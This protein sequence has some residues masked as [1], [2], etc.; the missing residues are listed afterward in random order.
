MVITKDLGAV[1]AYAYA[2]EQGYQG[3]EEEF[4]EL[5]ARQATVA[6]EAAASADAAAESASEA[7]ASAE[8]AEQSAQSIS[9]DVELAEQAATTATGKA[10][11]AATSATT[12]NGA[13]QTATGKAAQAEQS[14][15]AAAN[16]AS[17][18]A[19]SATNAAASATAAQTAKTAAE[20]AQGR[21]EQ[22]TQSVSASAAQIAKNTD[23]FASEFSAST[24]YAI[25]DYCIYQG[26]L[27]RFTSAHTGAWSASD[28]EATNVGEEVGELRSALSEV[29]T[30]LGKVESANKF[31]PATALEGYSIGTSG[32]PISSS[33]NFTSDFI[34]C[35]GGDT[36]YYT[37]ARI[38][39]SVHAFYGITAANVS[40]FAQYDENKQFIS[41]TRQQWVNSVVLNADC[42]YVRFSNPLTHLQD[43]IRI[44]SVTFNEYP[45]DWDEVAEYHEPYI[46]LTADRFNE[47]LEEFEDYKDE[48]AT[49]VRPENELDLSRILTNTVVSSSG[50]TYN[51]TCFT[52]DY[53]IPAVYGDVVTY[54][55]IDTNGTYYHT[56]VKMVNVGMYDAD[57]NLLGTSG[58]YAQDFKINKSNC[59]YIR[60]SCPNGALSVRLACVSINAVPVM[61]SMTEY[62]TP[63]YS[64]TK[65]SQDTIRSRKVLWLGTSIPTYG[66]PQILARLCGANMHNEAIGSSC[67]AEGIEPNVTAANVCGIRSIYGLYG[68]TQTIAE[69]QTMIDNWS[70]IASEIGSTDTLTD[71]IRATALASSYETIVDPYLTGENA[72]DLIVLNHAYNDAT[73]Y[74]VAPEGDKLNPHYLEGAYNWLIKRILEANPNIGIVIFG[75]YSD[76]PTSKE[77]ALQNVA[78]RWNIPYYLLKNDLGWSNTQ[79]IT[80]TKRI[81]GS[82]EWETI[83]A[84]DMTVQAM[85]LGDGVH[86]LGVASKR[87]A[88]VSQNVFAD[89]LK[90]Y[91]DA[92]T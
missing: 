78:D 51:D 66:Y 86:P 26:T 15:T 40:H 49:L 36:F 89:W 4:A 33:S 67:I 70:T 68:L 87:I 14:A 72:V 54:T 91:C 69:K 39:D 31:N 75:H 38:S 85:W 55:L 13:A 22:A 18:A 34:P 24:T 73:E 11:E 63:Y 3:T 46:Y 5:M 17:A 19:Q 74:A 30:A 62:F 7:Q 16:S 81:N 84:T 76:L 60:V 43:E 92:V 27:Y 29:D 56:A 32:T 90:M 35:N 2:V 1:S 9:G 61:A 6:E 65:P 83:T 77:T 42:R 58:F 8:Q 52:T 48:V 53:F 37:A 23:N 20:T 21:A 50:D 59:A 44:I 28:V 57:Y 25:G 79:T 45:A 82:G 41:G 10:I 71:S 88:Q 12:A 64:A 47:H 80:T